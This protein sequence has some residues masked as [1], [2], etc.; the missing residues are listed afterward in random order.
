[1]LYL[2]ARMLPWLRRLLALGLLAPLAKYMPVSGG[3][4]D[5]RPTK[6]GDID[7]A[8]WC[9]ALQTDQTPK[10]K[11]GEPVVGIR[12]HL[13]PQQVAVGISGGC[14]SIAIGAKK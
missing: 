6:A 3:E 12:R 4:I 1:M 9:R 8:P 5:A 7:T 10:C 11:L 13:E 2:D 14:E